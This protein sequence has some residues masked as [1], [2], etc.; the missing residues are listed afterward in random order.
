MEDLFDMEQLESAFGGLNQS[1][2]N[3]N[4]YAERMKEDDK[5]M[6][7]F[8]SRESPAAFSGPS[9]ATIP[10]FN[11]GNSECDSDD[12]DKEHEE[13]SSPCRLASDHL[14]EINLLEINGGGNSTM[15]IQ[16]GSDRAT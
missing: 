6:P 1:G 4:D 12:S 13:N 9:S 2:F 10:C 15:E 3:I 7:L 5:R 16:S 8:W 14:S 11:P